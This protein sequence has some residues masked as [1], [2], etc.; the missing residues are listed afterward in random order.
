VS[1]LKDRHGASMEAPLWA[2][3]AIASGCA[4]AVRRRIVDRKG[5]SAASGRS[6]KLEAPA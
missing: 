5:F 2:S 1:L 3:K 6:L 4:D